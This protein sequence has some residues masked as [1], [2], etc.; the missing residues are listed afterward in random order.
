MHQRAF[1]QQAA[2]SVQNARHG[3]RYFQIGMI[4]V[5]GGS[6]ASKTVRQFDL[7]ISV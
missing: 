4:F 3:D 5:D 7:L 1:A 2:D 6:A